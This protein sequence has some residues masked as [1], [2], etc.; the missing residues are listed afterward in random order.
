MAKKNALRQRT[1]DAILALSFLLMQKGQQRWVFANGATVELFRQ[2]YY[3]AW[4]GREYHVPIDAHDKGHAAHVVADFISGGE[5]LKPSVVLDEY[6]A[7]TI[8]RG[9]AKDVFDIAHRHCEEL[10]RQGAS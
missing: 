5:P 9:V 7:W 6:T 10:K 2:S 4:G 1:R 8:A 3:I